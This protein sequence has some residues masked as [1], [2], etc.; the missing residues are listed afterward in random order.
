MSEVLRC[1]KVGLLCIQDCP[2]DRPTMSSVI[3]MLSS[4]D[5]FLPEPKQPGFA[6]T[7]NSLNEHAYSNKK[8]SHT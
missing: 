4:D 1:I 8:K 3:L 7:E 2:E 5:V 6:V